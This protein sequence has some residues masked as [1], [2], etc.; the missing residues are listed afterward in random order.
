MQRPDERKV[1][2][3][4]REETDLLVGSYNMRQYI[5]LM[6]ISSYSL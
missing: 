1:A 6:V 5:S 4:C 2:G 3:I